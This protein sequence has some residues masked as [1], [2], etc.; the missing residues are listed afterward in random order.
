M[1]GDDPDEIADLMRGIFDYLME[2]GPVIGPGHTFG[3]DEQ[4]QWAFDEV[5]EDLVLPFESWD[6]IQLRRATADEA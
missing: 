6:M 5:P 1:D 3:E 4:A 2:N